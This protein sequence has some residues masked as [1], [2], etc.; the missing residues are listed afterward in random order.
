MFLN[1]GFFFHKT[2][3]T[4]GVQQPEFYTL[5]K[6]FIEQHHYRPQSGF[7][8]VRIK[9]LDLD[10]YKNESG[11]EQIARELGVPYPSRMV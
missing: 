10:A 6:A 3:Q 11:F 9:G 4:Q 1:I 7:E 5:P 8:K 2:G